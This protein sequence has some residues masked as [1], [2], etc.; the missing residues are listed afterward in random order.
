MKRAIIISILIFNAIALAAIKPNRVYSYTPDK[1]E[2]TYEDSRSRPTM[3]IP[4]M[5]GI[6]RQ[7][8]KALRS[9]YRSQMQAIWATGCTWDYTFRHMD[10]MSGC[11]TIVDSD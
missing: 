1:L 5:F 2:L 9:S 3:A 7:R 4:S 11:M 6:C 10:L 8:A